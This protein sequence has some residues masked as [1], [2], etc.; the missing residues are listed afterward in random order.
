[1]PVW[2][3]VAVA[4]LLA[5]VPGSLATT[6]VS[7]TE[8][9]ARRGAEVVF[10]AVAVGQALA[11]LPRREGTAEQIVRF[12]IERYRKG[13][14]PTE[15]KVRTGRW[16]EPGG[17]EGAVSGGIEP[18][19]DER[20]VIYGDKQSDGFVRTSYCDGSHL[21]SERGLF[22][23]G[24]DARLADHIRYRWPWIVAGAL[25][26]AGMFVFILRRSRTKTA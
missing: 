20:W 9:Q 24:P 25:V 10:E 11:P 12:R 2:S 5:D 8:E 13:R 15:V 6:C 14:G 22:E 7:R 19:V 16:S 17:L 3:L 26:L 21:A 1:V 18:H 4:L 23:M